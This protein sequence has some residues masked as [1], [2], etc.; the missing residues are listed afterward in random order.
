MQMIDVPVIVKLN[1]GTVRYRYDATQA[2]LK[3]HREKPHED[4]K[5]LA[6][7][8]GYFYHVKLKD[9]SEST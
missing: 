9:Y 2:Y 1:D 5:N 8:K 4:A 6:N 7:K 3:Q